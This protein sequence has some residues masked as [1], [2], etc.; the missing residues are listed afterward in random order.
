VSVKVCRECRVP[1]PVSCDHCHYFVCDTHC[2]VNRYGEDL[3]GEC[4][5]TY[6][7]RGKKPPA[8]RGS[9]IGRHTR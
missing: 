3:C 5:T 2:L 1:S 8:G 4:Y 7:A 6:A 9:H